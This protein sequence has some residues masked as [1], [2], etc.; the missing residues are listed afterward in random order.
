MHVENTIMLMLASPPEYLFFKGY[1]VMI[2]FRGQ[3]HNVVPMNKWM[4]G[5][6]KDAYLEHFFVQ[7]FSLVLAFK[8]KH[9]R[10]MGGIT[11]MHA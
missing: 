7:Y 2:T 6:I 9:V 3:F 8:N 1:S 10:N 5:R 11:D 4:N